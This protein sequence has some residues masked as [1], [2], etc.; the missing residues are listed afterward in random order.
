[1]RKAPLVLLCFSS[2]E[3]EY[4]VTS[5]PQ[6]K[7]GG[8]VAGS[9]ALALSDSNLGDG[10][11]GA[12]IRNPLYS[13]SLAISMLDPVRAAFRQTALMRRRGMSMARKISASVMEDAS[14]AE[15]SRDR[16]QETRPNAAGG[17]RAWLRR[18]LR[19]ANLDD[20]IEGPIGDGR[21][22]SKTY[23]DPIN[24]VWMLPGEKLSTKSQ[25]VARDLYE[26]ELEGEWWDSLEDA[27]EIINEPD[28]RRMMMI[29]VGA[30]AA[31]TILDFETRQQ[32][33]AQTTID[34]SIEKI[35]TNAKVETAKFVNGTV[36]GRPNMHGRL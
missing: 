24:R 15:D 8:I 7:K 11:L 32:L 31:A 23:D 33:L 13:L 26:E 25:A 35:V 10:S 27:W 18:K 36:L 6:Q 21:L 3:F 9:P 20:Y 1:M 19:R 17:K 28:N 16:F 2:Q 29:Q 30:L 12:E 34:E 22:Y 14:I 5:S 4:A